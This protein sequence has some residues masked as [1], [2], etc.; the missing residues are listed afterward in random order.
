MQVLPAGHEAM[1]K[2]GPIGRLMALELPPGTTELSSG[3]L[4]PA[5][6]LASFHG[7][8]SPCVSQTFTY[9][10]PP[11]APPHPALQMGPSEGDDILKGFPDLMVWMSSSWDF[12]VIIGRNTRELAS[13]LACEDLSRRHHSLVRKSPNQNPTVIPL[14]FWTFGTMRNEYLFSQVFCYDNPN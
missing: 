6:S 3:R 11:A 14:S 8:L 12:S 5:L 4:V 1:V 10:S 2:E 9:W 13:S 7:L